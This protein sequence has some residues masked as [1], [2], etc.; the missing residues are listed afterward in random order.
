MSIEN[1]SN[2]DFNKNKTSVPIENN[3]EVQK[4][5]S[6]QIYLQKNYFIQ[7]FLSNKIINSIILIFLPIIIITELFYRKPLFNK[8]L[9]AEEDLQDSIG[10][11]NSTGVKFF[12][13]YTDFAG[14]Y[15]TVICLIIVYWFFT[16]IET[17]VH[18]FGLIFAI[19][20][21]AV[22]KIWYISRRPFW[23]KNTLYMGVCDGGFGN[24]SGHSFIALFGYL[25]FLSYVLRNKYIK[26]KII[27][28]IILGIIFV[29]WTVL[30]PFS[31]VVL[32]VHSINQIVYGALLGIWLF[33]VLIIVFKCDRMPVYVY[34]DL[35][36]KPKYI[37]SFSIFFI[38]CLVLAIISKFTINTNIDKELLNKIIDENCS[39]VG[40]YKRL[41]AGSLHDSLII[42][43]SIGLYYGQMLFWYLIENKYKKNKQIS[44]SNTIE[45]SNDIISYEEYFA[46]DILINK[47][48]LNRT[49]T[50]QHWWNIFIIIA[51][52]IVC[53][54]PIFLYLFI[55]KT[56]TLGVLLTFRIAVPLFIALFLAFSLGLYGFI[57]VTC[58]TKEILLQR[59]EISD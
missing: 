10:G 29:I 31:R 25:T 23:E 38:I 14:M 3:E 33:L 34:K 35:F 21:H 6:N 53:A 26:D 42:A 51:I 11:K 57:L 32:G 16:I 40:D 43:G 46:I 56:T 49:Q 2:Q 22:M 37:I 5:I 8:S 17:F 44:S 54:L 45:N 4:T 55:P 30:V 47:W 24:P 48:T 1:N 41:H 15:I 9:T 36:R 19:Y 59:K 28:K 12:K 27:I 58:G 52:I 18:I 50:F 39:D 13:F 7:S 20:L